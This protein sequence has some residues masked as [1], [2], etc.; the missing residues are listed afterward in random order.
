MGKKKLDKKAA[1]AAAT[2]EDAPSTPAEGPYAEA[3]DHVERLTRRVAD[4]PK[5]GVE[6][7]DLMP[8]FADGAAFRLVVEAL[9]AAGRD[10]EGRGAVDLVAGIDSRGF[11]LGA[12]VA[13]D[14]GIGVLAVRKGGKLPPP[15]HSQKYTLEYGKAKL[16]IPAEGVDLYGRRVLLVDDVFATGGTLRAAG[17]LLR[18]CGATVVA[19]AVVLEI[20]GLGGRAALDGVPVTVLTRA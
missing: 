1:K 8:V 3:V 20:P 9:A 15:V 6:F 4:F 16:E 10:T 19:A 13:L 11:L 17:D 5:P 7:A 14:L 18:R 2:A 12:G